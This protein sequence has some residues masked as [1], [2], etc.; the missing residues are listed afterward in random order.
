MVVDTVTFPNT[1]SNVCTFLFLLQV[2]FCLFP[3]VEH[4][5]NC[6]QAGSPWF[7]HFP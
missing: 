3:A 1:Q 4:Y 6:E 5:T 2:V 7:K